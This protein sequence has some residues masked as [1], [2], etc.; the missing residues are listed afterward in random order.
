MMLEVW[1]SLALEQRGLITFQRRGYD[2]ADMVV[3]HRAILDALRKGDG[4]TAGQLLHDHARYFAHLH[5]TCPEDWS[6]EA[7]KTCQLRPCEKHQA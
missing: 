6:K 7:R 5:D 2:L 1:E 3:R 4:E